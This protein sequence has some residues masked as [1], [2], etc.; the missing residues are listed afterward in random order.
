MLFN[1]LFTPQVIDLFLAEVT[2][3]CARCRGSKEMLSEDGDGFGRPVSE[4]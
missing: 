1:W 4:L 3:P 2:Q